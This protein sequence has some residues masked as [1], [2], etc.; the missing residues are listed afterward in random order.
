MK[1]EQWSSNWG[2]ILAV[3]GSAVGLGNFLRFPG[4]AAQ[5][6]GG[7]FMLAYFISFLLIGLPIA[8]SEWIMGRAAGRNGY[9]SAPGI[10]AF[11]GKGNKSK[12]FGA[13]A[14]L[15]PLVVYMYYVCIEG[16]CL[17]YALN[18][19]RGE[20]NFNA[21]FTA[22]QYFG[23]FVGAS[24]D[25]A[26]LSW[27][28][29]GL[30]P[31]LFFVLILNLFFIY[32]GVS[33][34]IEK[35]CRF[36]MPVLIFLAFVILLRVLTLGTP[37]KT[38]PENNVWNG[39]GYMWNPT[40]VL[41]EKKEGNSWKKT[42]EIVDKEQISKMEKQAEVNS[43][44]R[45]RRVGM[46]EQLKNPDLWLAAAGQIFFS[47]SIGFGIIL[48]YSSYMN[49]KDDVVLSGLAAASAN[50]FCEVGLGGLLTLPAGVAFLGVA[51]VVGQGTFGL[52][53]TVLPQV[54]ST[55]P[56]GNFFG[57]LFFFML[58]LAALT[59][60]LSMLQPGISFLQESLKVSKK[61]AVLFL[62]GLTALGAF[63]VAYCS[64]SLKA[65]D[66]MD[67]WVGTFLIFLFATF[68][69]FFFN[70]S[71]GVKEAIEEAQMGAKIGL[72]RWFSPVIRY[73][74][75]VFLLGI[76][77]LWVSKNIFGFSFESGGGSTSPYINDILE[78]NPVALM[79]LGVILLIAILLLCII[80]KAKHLGKESSVNKA[81]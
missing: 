64:E 70:R 6:G 14:L 80:A 29:K 60:S 33:Q 15:I 10:L 35:I 27:G 67:F 20:F 69:V 38:K 19:F 23:A 72:P 17:S 24:K 66:T 39:L 49:Q 57:G 18:F 50:E 48:V 30:L 2:A 55:M 81:V 4:Q 59:S 79:S 46:F 13:L 41:V 34:G 25:G 62:G 73:I 40:K 71:F 47:I 42:Q 68:Q 61:V 1:K 74:C 8:W 32:R 26:G 77:S 54:F 76:F 58:F 3:A 36:G 53:F 7:A 12:Y 63:F 44:L 16:W 37:D 5:F 31:F 78:K 43:S 65:L 28:W 75:P 11:L 52:G 45:V 21:D 56:G 51:G 9:H 22:G